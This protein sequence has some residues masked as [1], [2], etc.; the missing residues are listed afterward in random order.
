MEKFAVEFRNV[1]KSYGDHPVVRDIS[2]AVA[3]GQLVTLIGPSGCGKTTT[4]KMVN[5]LIEPTSGTLLVHGEDVRRRNPV[6]LRR[7]I[8]Y[9]IQQIGLF[10]HLTIEENI[11]LVPR[12]NRQDKRAYLRRAEELLDLIGLDPA[13]F[14][15]RYP[16][17]LSGGQQQRVGVA[18]ALAADPDIIL[19]DEPFSA[20][21]P[22]SRESLQDELLRLQGTLRKT[23]LFVTHDMDEAMK[24]AD[25][26]ILMKD[27]EIVQADSPDQ[28]LR[29][30]KDEFVRD[31]V[32]EKRFRQAAWSAVAG[33][34]MTN[35]VTIS[36]SRGL[37]E[38]VHLMGRQRVNGLMVTDN[39]QHYL[40]VVGAEEVYRN[41]GNER[42]TVADVMN[43]DLPVVSEDTPL[44]RVL[45][46]MESGRG[47]L[48]VL[49][50]NRKLLGVVTRAS[51]IRLVVET[52]RGGAA[53][54]RTDAGV[55]AKLG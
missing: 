26:I 12:L 9:V 48:P 16:G 1:S 28:I 36:P 10:P 49:D 37:A 5:R 43:R 55:V 54:E 39:H 11:A 42:Q 2:F 14:R 29:H 8:G 52:Y 17:E 25:N 21:D 7:S 19:M 4:L 50:A 45:A 13:R 18:R 31:F 27:G 23:I 3:V 44:P 32:G 51:V 46:A 24:L 41:Y 47:Y 53:N 15:H 34:V 22:I 20:L 30:P 33:D 38:A 6:E 40:G 35:A